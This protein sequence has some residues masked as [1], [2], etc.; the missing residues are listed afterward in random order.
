MPIVVKHV[1][2]HYYNSDCG[3]VKKFLKI[4]NQKL[5]KIMAK[6]EQVDAAIASLTGSAGNISQDLNFL[7]EQIAAGTVTDESVAKL[8]A[9][10]DSFATIAASTDSTPAETPAEG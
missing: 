4:I 8:T 5:N 10:A 6:Q 3:G 9:L 7:K 1:H 2:N